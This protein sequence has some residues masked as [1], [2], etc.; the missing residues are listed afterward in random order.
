MQFIII[1][2]KEN[3]LSSTFSNNKCPVRG[4]LSRT[5]NAETLTCTISDSYTRYARSLYSTIALSPSGSRKIKSGLALT[6]NRL[7]TNNFEL[8]P[9][10]AYR[11]D[12][13]IPRSDFLSFA[14]IWPTAN[15]LDTQYKQRQQG[16]IVSSTTFGSILLSYVTSESCDQVSA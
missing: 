2:R 7:L 14:L 1:F 4:I 8:R 16:P 13:G 9:W 5:A 6:L 10:S 12:P 3:L 15:M 11:R